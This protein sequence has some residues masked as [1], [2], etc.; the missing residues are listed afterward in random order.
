MTLHRVEG[1]GGRKRGDVC[2]RLSPQ[3]ALTPACRKRDGE[4]SVCSRLAGG[5]LMGCARGPYPCSDRSRVRR[6]E[7][8]QSVWKVCE[9]A[10]SHLGMACV[11][12]Y[13][14]GRFAYP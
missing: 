3:P 14:R 4:S 2:Q 1:G 9:T 10:E 6:L 8:A 12:L 5:G 13:F 11:I 7:A